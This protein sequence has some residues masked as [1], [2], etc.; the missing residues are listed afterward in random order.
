MYVLEGDLGS[1]QVERLQHPVVR[2][3]ACLELQCA[4]R[5]VDVFQAVDDAVRVV[6]GRVDAPRIARMRVGYVLDTI[7][8]L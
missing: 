5:V 7:R 4:Y 6:V 2:F 8:H 3:S 1:V